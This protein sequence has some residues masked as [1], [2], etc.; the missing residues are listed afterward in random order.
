M[1]L[2]NHILTNEHYC[3]NRN[4]PTCNMGKNTLKFNKGNKKL[5][6]YMAKTTAIRDKYGISALRCNFKFKLS[7]VQRKS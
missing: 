2:R 5:G 7:I 1:F 4:T 6:A 3:S